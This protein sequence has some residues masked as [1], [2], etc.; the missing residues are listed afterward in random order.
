[1][2]W[3]LGIA[4]A[5]AVFVV[6]KQWGGLTAEKKKAATWKAVLVVGGALLVFMVLTGRV[7]VLTAAVAALLPLLRKLPE[8][9]RFVPGL[10]RFFSGAG[11]PSQGAGEQQRASQAQSS[12]MSEREAIEI[13][14]VTEDCSREV[15]VMAHR[16]LMQKLHPDRG[17]S[18]YLAAKINEAKSILLRNKV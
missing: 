17:G 14:G 1:M 10:N 13:L 8:I 15:V 12:D 6:L 2:Q 3:I 16:R 5:A 11:G 7:H 4:L 18:D 9:V